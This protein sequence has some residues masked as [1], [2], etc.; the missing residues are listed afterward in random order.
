M[1]FSPG[2]IRRGVKKQTP[3]V[4]CV[5]VWRTLSHMSGHCHGP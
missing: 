3:G 4:V 1:H 5:V 2:P